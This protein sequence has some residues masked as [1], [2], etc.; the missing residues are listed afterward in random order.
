MNTKIKYCKNCGHEILV[1]PNSHICVDERGRVQ[2]VI[3][4]EECGCEKPELD[5]WIG[6]G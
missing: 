3:K 1:K 2:R 5:E 4:C 6:V